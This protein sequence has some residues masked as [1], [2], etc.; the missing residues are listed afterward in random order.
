[1][2]QRQL[3]TTWTASRQLT[4]AGTVYAAGA[5]VPNAVAAGLRRLSALVSRNLLIPDRNMRGEPVDPSIPTPTNYNAG[6]RE[7]I[8]TTADPP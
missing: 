7:Q 8:A 6:E 4:L 3:P 5:T 1:M 2:P